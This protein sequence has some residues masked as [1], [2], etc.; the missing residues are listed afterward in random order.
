MGIVAQDGILLWLLKILPSQHYE[1]CTSRFSA[2]TIKSKGQADPAYRC[3]SISAR[4]V[5]VRD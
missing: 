5:S 2:V 4:A 3:I 1:Y